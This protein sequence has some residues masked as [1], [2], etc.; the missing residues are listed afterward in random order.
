V[1]SKS[2]IIAVTVP[3]PQDASFENAGLRAAE[4]LEEARRNLGKKPKAGRRGNFAALYSGISQGQGQTKPQ[5]VSQKGCEV[6]DKLYADNAFIRLA[7]FQSGR[8]LF[9]TCLT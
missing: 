5:M 6:C 1:D 4:L 8:Q 9:Y 7:G 2:R 3:P